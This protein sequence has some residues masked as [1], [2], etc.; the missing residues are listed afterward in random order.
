VVV[1]WWKLN[2]F[3]HVTPGSNIIHPPL[4]SEKYSLTAKLFCGAPYRISSG[5]YLDGFPDKAD[6]GGTEAYLRKN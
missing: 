2:I 6:I 3:D 4:K 5:A 1:D